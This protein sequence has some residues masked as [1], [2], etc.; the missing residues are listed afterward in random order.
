MRRFNPLLFYR[1]F[2]NTSLKHAELKYNHLPLS[3]KGVWYCVTVWC[4]L[5]LY[6]TFKVQKTHK[7]PRWVF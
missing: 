1:S 2:P 5:F 4:L 7:G 6:S 3:R